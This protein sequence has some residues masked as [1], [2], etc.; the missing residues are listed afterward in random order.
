MD[1]EQYAKMRADLLSNPAYS[2]LAPEFLKRNRDTGAL[3][4]FAKSVDARWEPRRQFLREQFEPLLQHLESGA[5]RPQR[6]MPGPYDSSAWTGIEDPVH[7]ARAVKTLIPVAQSAIE[8]LIDHLGQPNHNGGPPLDEVEEALDHLRKLHGK[9][10][11]ILLAA[12]EGRL[13]SAKGEGLMEEAAR[14]ARRATKSLK[15]DPLPYAL[16]AA[17]F[18]VFTACGFPGLGGYLPGIALAIRKPE[19]QKA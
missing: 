1:A 11:E 12:D 17:L 15:N 2:G 10:G 18:A 7:R 6:Q 13:T 14:Y 19:P 16:S 3:W 4:P 8:L 5:S 9:L